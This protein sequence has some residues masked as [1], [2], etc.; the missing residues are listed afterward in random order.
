MSIKL[1]IGLM[2]GLILLFYSCKGKNI[3]TQTD[4]L[5]KQAKEAVN[6]IQ[7]DTT[8]HTPL[9]FFIE[10]G[11]VNCIPCKMMQ[12]VMKSIEQKYGNQVKVFFYDVWQPDQR[13]YAKDYKIRVIPTQVFLNNDGNEIYR[14]EGFFPESEIDNF[15]QN[16]GLTPKSEG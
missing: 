13:H 14:H 12:P 11:S 7:K 4:L 8:E 10:L 6:L 3:E 9:I 16:Q 2:F 5:N 1:R 15:L